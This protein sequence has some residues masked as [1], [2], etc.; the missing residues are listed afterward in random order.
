M[1]LYPNKISY[2]KNKRTWGS[3]NYKNELNFNILL[4]RYPIYIMEYIVIHELA[5]IKYKNHSKDFWILVE[6]FCPNYKD[7]EKT[8]KSLL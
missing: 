8:F 5:H 2:R 3:C 7:I 6:K 1:Q 4:M